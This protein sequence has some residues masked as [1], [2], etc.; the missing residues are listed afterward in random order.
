VPRKL[1]KKYLPSHESISGN[2]FI[3]RFGSFLTH[4]NLWHLNRSSVAGGVAVGLLSGL[5]PGP[6]QILS[7]TILSVLLR[8]NLP[9]AVFT[10]F[11]TNPFTIVPLYI[12]AYHLGAWV[13]GDQNDGPPAPFSFQDRSVSE[14]IPHL[15]E[16]LL[17]MGKPL[18][19]GLPLF[20]VALAIAGYFAV[21][22]GWRL[23]VVWEWRK[24]ARVRSR[25]RV[26]KGE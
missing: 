3:A 18:A 20:A 13:T 11:Y 9:V 21:R 2:P 4:H 14:W 26:S 24:R 19:V 10:T 6:T 22:G 15:W 7:A 25:R 17:S 12:A 5:V 1:F 23:W 16:W 8:V